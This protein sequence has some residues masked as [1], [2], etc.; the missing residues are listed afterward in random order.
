M[1]RPTIEPCGRHGG[2]ALVLTCVDCCRWWALREVRTERDQWRERYQRERAER[3][4]LE[5]LLEQR[6]A[7]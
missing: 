4:R 2:E 7:S 6:R 5:G 1:K 3:I